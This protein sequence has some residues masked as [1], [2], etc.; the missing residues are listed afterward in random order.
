ME[1]WTVVLIQSLGCVE[2]LPR[3]MGVLIAVISAPSATL[4]LYSEKFES[5]QY[6]GMDVQFRPPE[7][8]L[9]S[10]AESLS[11][12]LNC[13]WRTSSVIKL[14]WRV[15]C[16]LSLEIRSEHAF[17]LNRHD[18]LKLIW[19]GLLLLIWISR[20]HL[21]SSELAPW[22]SAKS[23]KLH[24]NYWMPHVFLIAHLQACQISHRFFFFLT[25]P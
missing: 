17:Q 10:L 15:L 13:A 3:Y 20:L 7:A 5:P 21:F 9:V 6:S 19:F 12:F 11:P 24:L 2:P 23:L 22:R 14:T 4:I 16:L 18:G 8:H 25:A 1:L